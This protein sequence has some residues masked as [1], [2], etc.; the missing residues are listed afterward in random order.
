MLEN[1]QI[2]VQA[3]AVIIKDHHILLCKTTGL[4]PNFYFLPG[5]HIEH[6]ESAHNAMLRELREE[7][8]FEFEIKRVLGCMEYAYDPNIT[9]YAKC[10]NHEYN[11]I[12]EAVSKELTAPHLPLK[13]LE[14]HIEIAWIPMAQL[15]EIDL[16]PELLKIS[17]KEWLDSP[18]NNSFKSK[19][20]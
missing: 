5:G 14:K 10:H 15:T 7:I 16:R 12:F 18:I 9:K 4:T 17:I 3:R 1:N 2:H 11:F 19:M 6:Q 8:G 20:L 13:Q